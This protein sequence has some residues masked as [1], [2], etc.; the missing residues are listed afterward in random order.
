MTYGVRFPYRLEKWISFADDATLHTD[1]RLTN[2]SGFDFDFMWAAH[3]M[4][5]WKRERNWRC[6]PA[7]ERSSRR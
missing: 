3:M 6:L 2:L 1:Y 4:L 5:I 7:C